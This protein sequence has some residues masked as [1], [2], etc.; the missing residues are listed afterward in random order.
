MERTKLNSIKQI[1]LAM[2]VALV[3]AFAVGM[4]IHTIRLLYTSFENGVALGILVYF[5]LQH[6]SPLPLLKYNKHQ[7]TVLAIT[8]LLIVAGFLIVLATCYWIDAL[9]TFRRVIDLVPDMVLSTIFTLYLQERIRRRD[10]LR[11]LKDPGNLVNPD[12]PV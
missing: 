12:N 11:V 3:V 4:I 9:P 6:W 5:L 2:V 10:A 8:F 1:W 7:Y